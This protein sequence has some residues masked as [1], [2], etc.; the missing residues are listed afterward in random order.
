MSAIAAAIRFLTVVP[1]P[2]G[3][4]S[5]RAASRSVA[6]FPAVGLGIGGA[7][8]V[9]NWAAR[10]TMPDLPAAALAL[11]AGV[12]LTGALHLD[13][14]AD[15]FDGLF[16]GKT[17]KRR[18]EI[19]KDPSIGVYG[20]AAVVLV[21][22]TKWAG[23]SS[24]P[25][26]NGWAAIAVA[27]MGGRLAAVASMATFRY[28]NSDGL[29]TPFRGTGLIAYLAAAVFAAALA[30]ILA[31]PFG[32]AALACAVLVGLGVSAFAARRLG[33]GV[34]G[35]VYGASIELAEVSA[36][37]AFVAMFSAG[38]VIAPVWGG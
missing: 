9:V 5:A 24:M 21:L 19:M 23:L 32:L 28:E 6:W 36:L 26:L 7:V 8:A 15:T 2:G 1:A 38:L 17:P 33:G 25:D 16:G 14:L 20:V 3:E 35:D 29:G 18:L 11:A 31:G 4:W 22:V 37:L 30:F 12:V 13:G 27:V 10:L 34:T